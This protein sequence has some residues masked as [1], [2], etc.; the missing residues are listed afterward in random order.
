L[1]LVGVAHYD[2]VM[3]DASPALINLADIH[4]QVDAPYW[5]EALTAV[6]DHEVR[7]SVMTH[8]FDWHLHPDSDETFLVL[9]GEIVISFE[10]R[11]VLLA[12]GEMLT[13][14][15]GTLHKTR[16]NGARSVNLTFER[17]NAEMIFTSP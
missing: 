1:V 10:E 4:R 15:R 2:R 17:A 7:M 3:P 13:V 16:P 11:E 9:E 5:N 8:P 14:P 6:N 12:A